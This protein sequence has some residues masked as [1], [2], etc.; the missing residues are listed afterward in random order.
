M[1]V[2]KVLPVRSQCRY[3]IP[4]L[5]TGGLIL[6]EEFCFLPAGHDGPHRGPHGGIIVNVPGT[7]RLLERGK[8]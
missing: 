4:I 7:L 2:V 8:L 5:S 6:R 1:I 3:P